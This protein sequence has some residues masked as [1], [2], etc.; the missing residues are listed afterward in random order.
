[1]KRISLALAIFFVFTC[2]GKPWVD[3]GNGWMVKVVSVE[4]F[5]SLE[6]GRNPGPDWRW[7]SKAGLAH[8]KFIVI[9]IDIRKEGKGK[10]LTLGG[11]KTFLIDEGG[12]KYYAKG[13][14]DDEGYV[15]TV[16]SVIHYQT[17]ESKIVFDVP[18]DA[19]AL[20]LKV[21][22]EAEAVKI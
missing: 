13:G 11:K 19:K 7:S 12:N 4:E 9:T 18:E 8:G 22:P 3:L 1:M 2:G 6:L 21:S 5:N 10:P 15:P 17:T 16:S 14:F 20:V